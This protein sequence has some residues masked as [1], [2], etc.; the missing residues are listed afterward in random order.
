VHFLLPDETQR[1]VWENE[2]R[3]NLKKGGVISFSHGFNI[4]FNQIVPREDLDVLMIA[5]KGPGHMVRRTYE[6]GKGT[7]A[8]LA[9]EQ[10][11]SGKAKNLALAYAEGIGALRAGVIETTFTEETE[12]DNF[13]EQVVHWIFLVQ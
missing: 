13:G 2:I 10:D 4:R 3:D 8:L 1:E 7:P 5:P 6:E 11:A 9:I 12:T